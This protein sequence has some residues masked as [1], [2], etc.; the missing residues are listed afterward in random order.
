MSSR[1]GALTACH[2]ARPF[3]TEFGPPGEPREE[4]KTASREEPGGAPKKVGE[5]PDL[6]RGG[7]PTFFAEFGLYMYV[8][9]MCVCRY[10]NRESLD[11]QCVCIFVGML[12]VNRRILNVCVGMFVRCTSTLMLMPMFKLPNWEH[13]TLRAGHPWGLRRR[14][15]RPWR[16]AESNAKRQD[17]S[18][19]PVSSPSGRPTPSPLVSGERKGIPWHLGPS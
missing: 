19:S 12:T 18:S 5:I 3:R 11:T 4:P 14:H 6:F 16:R 17:L 7:S 15:P 13:Y 1:R 9:C 8:R 2:L 10:V